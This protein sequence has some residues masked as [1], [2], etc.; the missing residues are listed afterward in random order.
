M[1]EEAENCT[2]RELLDGVRRK[3]VGAFERLAEQYRSLTEA[4]VR[5]FATS[6]GITGQMQ[7]HP[8]MHWTICGSM[9]RWHCTVRRKRTLPKIRGKT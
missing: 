9:P 1:R 8:C 2:L 4:A 5:R 7:T 6:F 3:D